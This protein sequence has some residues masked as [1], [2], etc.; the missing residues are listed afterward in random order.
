MPKFPLVLLFGAI[1]LLTASQQK[2]VVKGPGEGGGGQSPC[3]ET[4]WTVPYG[5]ATLEVWVLAIDPVDSLEVKVTTD[6][7]VTDTW[8]LPEW[9]ITAVYPDSHKVYTLSGATIQTDDVRGVRVLDLSVGGTP[10][11]FVITTTARPP[12]NDPIVYL[13]KV[14]R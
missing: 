10:G 6:M 2:Q 5:E 12:T 3:E 7:E 9:N 11:S 13:W 1:L 8:H 4:I 14:N